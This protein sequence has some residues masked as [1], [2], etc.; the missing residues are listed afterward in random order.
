MPTARQQHKKS[1]RNPKC[2]FTTSAE[3]N[4]TIIKINHFKTTAR[5]RPGPPI[6]PDT[7]VEFMFTE[8]RL[9]RWIVGSPVRVCRCLCVLCVRSQPLL[10]HDLFYWRK[11]L[12][13]NRTHTLARAHICSNKLAAN[14]RL[15]P[16]CHWPCAFSVKVVVLFF[17]KLWRRYKLRK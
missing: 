10:P 17:A 4:S 3:R 6:R 9:C 15:A 14:M 1:T 12:S 5:Q 7:G 16:L 8:I 2:A 13:R 11:F